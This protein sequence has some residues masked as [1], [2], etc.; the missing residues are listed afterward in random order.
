MSN[1]LGGYRAIM[2]HKQYTKL[3]A[4]NVINRFGDSIDAIAFTWLVYEL[5]GSA[6]WSAIIFGVNMLPTVVLGPFAGALAE[7][8]D[9]KWTMVISDITRGLLVALTAALYVFNVLT[10]VLMLFITLAHST[11]EA[12]RIPC[13]MAIVP[14]LLPKEDYDFGLSLNS[15]LSRVTEVVGLACAA[16]I[17]AA[18]DIPGAIFIDGV[19]FFLSALLIALIKAAQEKENGEQAEKQ[20]YWQTL[21]GGISYVLKTPAILNL[22]M[23]ALLLNSLLVPLSA[24]NAPLV[25]MYNLGPEAMSV[26]GILLTAG[27]GLGAF[28][29]PYLKRRLSGKTVTIA[30]FLAISVCYGALVWLKELTAV[31]ALFF[32]GIC[33]TLLL[34]SVTMALLSGHFNVSVMK[35]VNQEYL[36]R[37]GSTMNAVCTLAMPVISFFMGGLTLLLG[38]SGVL[39]LFGGI[40]FVSLMLLVKFRML[41]SMD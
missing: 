25:N 36:A 19:T 28:I 2:R 40:C 38:L 23:L 12:F 27:A 3:I 11:V 6:A 9:K 8:M 5:S 17:I 15:S 1:K 13:G 33:I 7:H 41:Y 26:A 21:K 10:P 18:I 30:G 29:Y 14:R 32:T 22:C 20:D 34:F 37:V 16:G 31:P 39:Y 4:A 35:L 24:L